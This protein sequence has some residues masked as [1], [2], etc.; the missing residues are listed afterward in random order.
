MHQITRRTAIRTV[1]G[2]AGLTVAGIGVASAKE[3]AG[4]TFNDQSANGA[5]VTVARTNLPGGG[6]VVL[7]DPGQDFDVIGHSGG[8]EAG[9]FHDVNVAIQRGK[10]NKDRRRMDR[11][12]LAMAHRDT[13][14][15]GEFEFPEADPPYFDDRNPIVDTAEITF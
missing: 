14:E 15:N 8:L 1:G 10:V 12:L 4:I 11:T 2:L 6:W 3:T 7:H 5:S 9:T 13:G